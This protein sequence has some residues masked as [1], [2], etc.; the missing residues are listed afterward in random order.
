MAIRFVG[1]ADV[2]RDFF[3][4]ATMGVS[5]PSR[6]H[7][8][9]R[10]PTGVLLAPGGLAAAKNDRHEERD[11]LGLQEGHD[12]DAEKSAIQQQMADFDA[13]EGHVGQEPLQKGDRR[14]VVFDPSERQ[15]IAV[16]FLDQT[17]GRVGE[18]LGGAPARFLVQD[19]AAR[20][21]AVIGDLV[22]I[23]GQRATTSGRF[24]RQRLAQGRVELGFEHLPSLGQAVA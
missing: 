7:L 5:V 1:H 4:L 2:H 11:V 6:R 18:E 19:V 3:A 9:E 23:D 22:Q 10:S 21:V 8:Q 15:R 16:S 17:G 24:G 20:R 14:L 12:R 13:A